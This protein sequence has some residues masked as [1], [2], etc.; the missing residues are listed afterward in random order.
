MLALH[1]FM[2]LAVFQV[3]AQAAHLGA[4]STVGTA[5]FHHLAH[6]ATTAVAHAQGTMHK[7]LDGHLHALADAAHLVKTQLTGKHQLRETH[8]LEK[9]RLLGRAQVALRACMQGNGRQVKPQD[10]H[11]LHNDGIDANVIK[12]GNE[13]LHLLEFMVID[14]RVDGSIDAGVELVGK[15]DGPRHLVEGIA[16]RGPCPKSRSTH[17]H[18][19]GAMA[20]RLDGDASITRR[21]QELYFTSRL[22]HC[23]AK[24]RK[25][26][27][28]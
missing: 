12:V 7:G 4:L 28:I 2:A 22:H 18:G 13:T 5:A 16:G 21:C 6:L 19:I 10:A 24:L 14:Q 23:G 11:I 1:E 27:V 20:D 3:I 9:A 25:T 26:T 15:V 8:R 17:I